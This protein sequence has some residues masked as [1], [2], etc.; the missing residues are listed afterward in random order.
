LLDRFGIVFEYERFD[1]ETRTRPDFYF[2]E[3][4]TFVEIHPVHPELKRIPKNCALL[5]TKNQYRAMAMAL[6]LRDNRTAV[7]SVV[8]DMTSNELHAQYENTF[9]LAV[10]LRQAILERDGK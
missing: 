7:Y 5:T 9:S 1:A 3:R 10:H 2:P 4:D 8:S 6:A